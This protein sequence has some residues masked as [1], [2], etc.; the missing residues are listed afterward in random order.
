MKRFALILILAAFAAAACDNRPHAAAGKPKYLW[1]DATANFER[2]AVR[3]SVDF[4]LDKACRAGF[5]R[6]VVDVRPIEGDVL[7]NSDLLPRLKTID[8]TTVDRDWDYLRYFIDAAHSRGMKVTASVTVFAAGSPPRHQGPVYDDPDT[9][10]GRTCIEYTP[11]GM[12]DIRDQSD[13]VAAFLNPAMPENRDYAI[14]FIGEL[15]ERYDIDGLSLD[16]CRYPDMYGDFS[17]FSRRDFEHHIG[18]KVDTWPQDIFSFDTSGAVVPG[19][20]YHRWWSYRAGVISSFIAAAADTV[21]ALRPDTELSY[22][23]ASWI[24][25]LYGTA[26]NWASASFPL[27]K[28]PYTYEWCDEEYDRAGFAAHLD[29]FM[30][31][32]YLDRIYG[33]D[34]PESIEFATARARRAIMGDCRLYGTIYAPLH[35]TNIADAVYVCLRDTEGLMVFDICQ[36]IEFDLWDDIRSGILRAE[37]DIAASIPE[38]PARN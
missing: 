17:D 23:A 26:Q 21:H 36:V 20:L 5:N 7:Y 31:G 27:H 35:K 9:F 34:D 38:A 8:G 33:P 12:V 14:A 15:T 2:F 6:I 18:R 25:G 19:P 28:E 16:Y 4:Y 3:D 10:A 30:L 37:P 11:Q 1:F 13:K 22:W 32:A 29:S 24:N